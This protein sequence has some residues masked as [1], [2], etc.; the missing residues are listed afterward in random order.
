M[1]LL[2]IGSVSSQYLMIVSVAPQV[3]PLQRRSY[4]SAW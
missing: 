1:H 2:T 4:R 3:A